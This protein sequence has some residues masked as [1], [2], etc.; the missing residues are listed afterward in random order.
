[1]TAEQIVRALAAT[2]PID[3]DG[4]KCALC[5]AMQTTAALAPVISLAR[6]EGPHEPDCPWLMAVEWVA[7]NATAEAEP[8]SEPLATEVER[9]RGVL[10]IIVAAPEHA[11]MY[12]EAALDP[13]PIG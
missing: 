9:L 11:R 12:A 5:G 10:A 2:S 1:M 7:E 13:K 4:Y 6:P 8:G 3:W